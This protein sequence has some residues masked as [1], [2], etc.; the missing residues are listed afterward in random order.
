ME[1]APDTTLPTRKRG[2]RLALA[3]LGWVMFVIGP[4]IGLVVPVIPIGLMIFLIGTGLVFRNSD[5][6]KRWIQAATRWAEAR[7]PKLYGFMP[8]RVRT[9]LAEG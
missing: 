8:A 6:G 5:R 3:T 1:E 4:L 9:F 2:K 7:F